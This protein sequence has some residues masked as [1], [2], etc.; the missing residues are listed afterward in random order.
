[1]KCPIFVMNK[2]RVV[3]CLEEECAWFH[4]YDIDTGECSLLSLARDTELIKE[5]VQQIDL[6]FNPRK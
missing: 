2:M 4:V 5:S 6:H 3:D 1:M